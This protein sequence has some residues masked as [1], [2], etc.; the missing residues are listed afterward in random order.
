MNLLDILRRRGQPGADRPDRLI[1]HHQITGRRAVRQRALELGAADIERLAGIALLAGLADADDRDEPGPPDR[2][3]L[4]AHQR[5]ALAMIGAPL[6]MAD[7][8]RLLAPASA[9]IS[10]EISPVCAPEALGWQSCAPTVNAVAPF[11]LPAK[12]ATSVA[13][14]QTRRSALAATEAAPASIASN[15]PREAL[16]P[17]IFQLPAISGRMASVMTKFPVHSS[18]QR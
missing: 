4:G 2:L 17:F 18:K 13:G 9:S 7:D 6:G 8:D 5:V 3:G 10:A 16:R 11:A 12:A 1:G 14:G 15:S